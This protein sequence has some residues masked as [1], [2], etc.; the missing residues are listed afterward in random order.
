MPFLTSILPKK[1]KVEF[2]MLLY[3][4]RKEGFMK[5]L[6]KKFSV[7]NF[8]GF[9]SSASVGLLTLMLFNIANS[10]SCYYVHEPKQPKAIEDFKWIK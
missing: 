4:K 5:K 1:E 2:N 3:K 10:A 7:K 9:M 6:F 8:V